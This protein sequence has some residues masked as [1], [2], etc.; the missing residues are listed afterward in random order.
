MLSQ[1]LLSCCC[2][3]FLKEIGGFNVE[4]TEQSWEH[5][6]E[7]SISLS[8]FTYLIRPDKNTA[9][10]RSCNYSWKVF[11][12]KRT[13]CV[14]YE[15][16]GMEKHANRIT[17]VKY[18]YWKVIIENLKERQI[19]L[20]SSCAELERERHY[21]METGMGARTLLLRS[22]ALSHWLKNYIW[23]MFTEINICILKGSEWRYTELVTRHL[24]SCK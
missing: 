3:S 14:S 11:N 5:V 15:L 18:L 10:I 8:Q 22:R 19:E 24:N 9:V 7:H 2:V 17:W 20:R 13:R 1:F 21:F 4:E 23:F 12:Y 6:S 16:H